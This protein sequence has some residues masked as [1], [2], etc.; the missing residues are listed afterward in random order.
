MTVQQHQADPA[1]FQPHVVVIGG[2][3]GGLETAKRLRKAN[4]RVTLI[5]RHNYHLFQPLLYQV[6]TGGLSPAN[7]STPLRAIIGRQANCQFV[8]GEV[9][10]FDLD[11][12]RVILRDGQV[13]FDYLVVAAGATSN[14]FGNDHWHRYATG[15]KTLEDA[16]QMRRRIY[17]AYEAAERE[18]DPAVKKARMTFVIVGG[19]P[20]G[21]ELA[22]ALSEIARHTLKHDFR[23]IDP[24]ESRIVLVEAGEKILAQYPDELCDIAARDLRR[25]GVEVRTNTSVIELSAGRVVIK[26]ETREESIDATTVLWAAGVA[27]S[28]LAKVLAQAS[29]QQLDRSGHIPVTATLNV[30]GHDNIFVIG[31]MAVVRD[32]DGEALP[33]VAPV[34]IQQGQYVAK[35]IRSAATGTAAPKPFRYR[36][37]GSMATIG[38][39]AAIAKIGRFECSGLL[40]WILWLAV[41]LVQIMQV[42]NRL[43]ILIQWAWNY[44]TFNRAARIITGS[45]QTIRE[46]SPITVANASARSEALAAAADGD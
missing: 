40:A 11:R 22:G 5:D 9:V 2:G 23:H 42:P 44:F 7:I 31:D 4:V 33:G 38:R 3:F 46:D 28:P 20:T 39:A 26:S 34:A 8:L 10:D 14:F 35:V 18:R 41:H 1:A 43:L 27:A 19:G 12:R 36:D 6:G 25:L 30:A 15:L 29:N 45:D 17:S 24:S 32:S 21:V 37:L 16:I 13:D